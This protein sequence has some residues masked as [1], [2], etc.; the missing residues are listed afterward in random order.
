MKVRVCTYDSPRMRR[1]CWENGKLIYAI[2]CSLLYAKGFSGPIFFG[3]NIGEWETGQ[4]VGDPEAMNKC[5]QSGERT[6][7]VKEAQR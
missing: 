2:D 7:M 5:D 4:I 6:E 3:A 1:E